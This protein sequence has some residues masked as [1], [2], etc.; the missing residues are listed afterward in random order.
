MEGRGGKGGGRRSTDRYRNT[1]DIESSIDLDATHQKGWKRDRII[2]TVHLRFV[3]GKIK[4][5]SL[6]TGELLPL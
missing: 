4:K 1:T 3:S 2:H 5:E 6:V